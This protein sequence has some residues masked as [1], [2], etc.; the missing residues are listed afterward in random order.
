M[1]LQC[2]YFRT[3]F[4]SN[5][6]SWP[7]ISR[8][9]LTLVAFKVIG[10][11]KVFE[12][13]EPN[14]HILRFDVDHTPSPALIH[15]IKRTVKLIIRDGIFCRI[16]GCVGDAQIST[17]ANDTLG[18]WAICRPGYQRK[19]LRM[20]VYRLKGEDMMYLRTCKPTTFGEDFS[21][22]VVLLHPGA[23]LFFDIFAGAAREDEACV[24]AGLGG[25]ADG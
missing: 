11:I 6:S 18:W 14:L 5:F 1:Y 25:D 17:L 2:P 24:F 20:G 21:L 12:V 19:S 22:D 13:S 3:S 16:S 8:N 7:R 4:H 23:G 9:H 10:S 15:I